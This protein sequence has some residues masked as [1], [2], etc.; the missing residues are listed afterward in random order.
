MKQLLKIT[1]TLLLLQYA[2]YTHA[3]MG[4]GT[5]TPDVS[6]KLD[7]TATDKGFLMPRMTTAQRI[8][9]TTPATGLQVYDET[10]NSIWFYN[11]TAWTELGSS[12]TA[13]NPAWEL[14][15]NTGTND[16][17]NFIGTTDAEDLIFKTNNIER[18]KIES[19]GSIIADTN[20]NSGTFTAYNGSTSGTAIT[21][22]AT[23]NNGSGLDAYSNGG[24]AL[25]AYDLSST[26]YGIY[27][28]ASK[29]PIFAKNTGGVGWVLTNLDASAS[30]TGQDVGVYGVGRASDSAGG[31]FESDDGFDHAF[32]SYWNGG[33]SYKI[34][35]SGSVATIVDDLDGNKVTMFCPE[36]PEITFTDS[37]VGQL[38]NGEA[39][40]SLDPILT[41]NIYVD[42]TSPLKVFVQLEGDCNGVYVTNKSATGFTVKE[43]QNGNANVP[44]SWSLIATRADE[45]R[46]NRLGETKTSKHVGVR[47]QKITKQFTVQKMKEIE[48][49]HPK[50]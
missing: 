23:G 36:S 15:G 46:S 14:L 18:M 50:N 1:I 31:Y 34:T 17:T 44:F 6:A 24:T 2:T 41:K 37:G 25:Y 29:Y 10:T 5:T 13:G 35:G 27:A 45:T 19:Y 21:G 4:I 49:N 20:S 38:I 43:L 12:G 11:G 33:T 40:I 28:L 8:A 26:G 16:A 7:I 39:Q 9:I 3:Q 47:F 32:V 30:F 48:K 42:H 22:V